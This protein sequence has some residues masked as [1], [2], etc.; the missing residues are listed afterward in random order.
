MVGSPSSAKKGNQESM[1]SA[2]AA[3]LKSEDNELYSLVVSEQQAPQFKNDVDAL[4]KAKFWA[5]IAERMSERT[6]KQCRERWRNSVDPNITQSKWTVREDLL[7]LK[8]HE[9]MGNKWSTI[10]SHLQGRTENGVK[11]RH[12]SIMRAYKR[13][14]S[15]QEDALLLQLYGQHG[16]RWVV[17]QKSLPKRTL[18]G[19]KMRYRA[20]ISGNTQRS[21]EAGAPEQALAYDVRNMSRR[22]LQHEIANGTDDS[23]FGLP[24]ASKTK[25]RFLI[26]S[27]INSHTPDGDRVRETLHQTKRKRLARGPCIIPGFIAVPSSMRVHLPIP[28][29]HISRA[30]A[31]QEHARRERNRRR[32]LLLESANRRLAEDK[33]HDDVAKSSYNT[34]GNIPSNQ[35]YGVKRNLLQEAHEVSRLRHGSPYS[36]QQTENNNA[37]AGGRGAERANSFQ[38]GTD[39]R[40]VSIKSELSHDE[41]E[42]FPGA[43]TESGDF[44]ND[45]EFAHTIS[46]MLLNAK[47]HPEVDPAQYND[48]QANL[49]DVLVDNVEGLPSSYP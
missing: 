27:M 42:P 1:R 25:K 15:S 38:Y 37:Y 43:D 40:D 31:A 36:H 2:Y 11:T 49:E 30:N 10:A 32:S 17:I 6:A 26:E 9:E 29:Q 28:G 45:N 20:L 16:P 8:L 24:G 14:W 13:Q 19:V 39:G 33:R 22:Q 3:W 4:N 12:K 34:S 48:F 7:L 46:D 23:A 35:E 5:H 41:G 47:S 44:L 18:H 21:V